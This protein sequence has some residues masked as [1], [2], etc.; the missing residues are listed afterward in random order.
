[1]AQQPKRLFSNLSPINRIHMQLTQA[2]VQFCIMKGD[3]QMVKELRCLYCS[4]MT[5]FS[6]WPSYGM[7]AP[8]YNQTREK[9]ER[10][11]GA[12]KIKVHCQNCTED[13]FVVWDRDPR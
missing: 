2:I 8:F 4:E 6:E 1:M 7:R 5:R 12:L 11:P 10:E 13:F 9:T 3:I